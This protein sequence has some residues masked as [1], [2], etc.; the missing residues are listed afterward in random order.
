MMANHTE[1]AAAIAACAEERADARLLSKTTDLEQA[2]KLLHTDHEDHFTSAQKIKL[3]QIFVKHTVHA[4][5]LVYMKGEL[6]NDYLT[7]LLKDEI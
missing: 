2:L 1:S 3:A 6:R 4:T 5:A 7:Q